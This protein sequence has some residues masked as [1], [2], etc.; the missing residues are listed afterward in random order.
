MKRF[1]GN[2]NCTLEPLP[3]YAEIAAACRAMGLHIK[4]TDYEMVEALLK[5]PGSPKTTR[6]VRGRYV[7]DCDL[8]DLA[9][10]AFSFVAFRLFGE[11]LKRGALVASAA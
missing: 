2:S 11:W 3:Y 8:L 10:F 7:V 9:F 5:G 4:D 1:Q 6:L